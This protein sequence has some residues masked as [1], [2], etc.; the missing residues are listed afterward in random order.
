VRLVS[1][2][3]GEAY[4]WGGDEVVVLLPATAQEQVQALED[5][6]RTNVA[7]ECS[8]HPKLVEGEATVPVS[9]GSH[10]FSGQ[11]AAAEI[12]KA[13]DELMY[14]DK[15]KTRQDRTTEGAAR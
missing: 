2:A 1:P 7:A 5:A 13:A 11:Q 8:A 4:A 10:V 12:V 3:K 14:A 6:I 15:K 9:I